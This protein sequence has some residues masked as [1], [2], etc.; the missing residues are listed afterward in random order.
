VNANAGDDIETH[1]KVNIYYPFI[2]H[3][4][5]HLKDRFPEELKGVLLV[6]YLIPAKLHLLDKTVVVKIKQSVTYEV[7]RIGDFEQEVLTLI[8]Y[9]FLITSPPFYF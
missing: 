7:L 8:L 4:I 2:V 5:Q 1:C 9:P 6:S 3:G